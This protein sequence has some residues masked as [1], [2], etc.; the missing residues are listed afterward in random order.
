MFSASTKAGAAP[1]P[2]APP[3]AACPPPPPPPPAA[4]L[5][6]LLLEVS[7]LEVELESEVAGLGS[8]LELSSVQPL[9]VRL[10]AFMHC[11]VSGVAYITLSTTDKLQFFWLKYA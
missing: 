11:N 5:F 10:P 8:K 9:T 7:G 6:L 3:P 4:P 1:R 2:P